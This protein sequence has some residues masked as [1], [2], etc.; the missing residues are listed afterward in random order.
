MNDLISRYYASAGYQSL[1]P[2]TR[3]TYRNTIEHLR[4][5]YGAGPVATLKREHILQ[6]IA[7]KAGKPG[8]ANKLLKSSS[9]SCA[10]PLKSG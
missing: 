10:L 5:E 1:R 4:V 2:A 6:I 9:C 7:T 3:Y 8:A